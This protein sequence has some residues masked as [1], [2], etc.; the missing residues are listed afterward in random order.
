MQS[1]ERQPFNANPL[2]P[3]PLLDNHYELVEMVNRAQAYSTQRRV[4]E[5]VDVV[6]DKSREAAA[7]WAPGADSIWQQ[8]T[9]QQGKVSI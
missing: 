7:R 4:Y 3:C 1:R 8:K 9:A 6:S 2:R 5:P